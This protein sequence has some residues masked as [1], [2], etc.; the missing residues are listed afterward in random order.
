MI[1]MVNELGYFIKE[2]ADLQPQTHVLHSVH[3]DAVLTGG[4]ESRFIARV[5]LTLIH[6]A[7]QEG[8]L[9]TYC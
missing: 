3:T 5:G 9:K 4:M 2:L 1:L 6:R 7:D 8:R